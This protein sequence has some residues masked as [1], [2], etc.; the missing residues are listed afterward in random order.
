[1]GGTSV[2]LVTV[3]AIAGSR[4]TIIPSFLLGYVGALWSVGNR[5]KR[6]GATPV[7]LVGRWVGVGGHGA[8]VCVIQQDSAL[9]CLLEGTNGL[10]GLFFFPFLNGKWRDKAG[11]EIVEQRRSER[12]IDNVSE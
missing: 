6:I 12:G 2:V 1:M 8:R 5:R 9:A 7:A 10:S 3:S 4:D 11:K